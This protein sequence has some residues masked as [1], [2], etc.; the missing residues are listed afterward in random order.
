MEEEQKFEQQQLPLSAGDK[1]RTARE[2]MGLTVAQVAAETR[3]NQ[4]HIA[5]IEAGDFAG[6]PARAYAVGFSRTYAKVVG[7]DDGEIARDVRAEL[8][9]IA[10]RDT[11]ALTFEPG[12][13]LRV[14][15]AKLA[16]F[17]AFAALIV[18]IAVVVFVS[19]LFFAPEAELPY[20]TDQQTEAPATASVGGPVAAV[21]PTTGPVVF[22]SLEDGI[23]VK[24]YD[25]AGRQ[26]MQK[27]MA[28]GETYTV[29][30]DAAGP[31][32]W[33]GRPDAL[34]ITVGGREVPRIG[35]REQIVRDVPVTAEALLARSQPA[36]TPAVQ[37]PAPR[38]QASPTI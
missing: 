7:L 31:Q 18:V 24:F 25:Q 2:K 8:S 28:K 5:M 36:A 29:P 13:P 16:W 38:T 4:R 34:T 26:L 1:L 3:I 15:S 11:R 32:L 12:D 21:A 35:E 9:M 14:P 27:Q 17:S 19:R 30:A 23:W 22:T 10:P 6:L 20:L 33:T 37:T